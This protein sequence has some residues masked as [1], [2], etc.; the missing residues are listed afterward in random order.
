MGRVGAGLARGRSR[1]SAPGRHSGSGRP[2]SARTG[3][4]CTCPGPARASGSAADRRARPA[5]R[6]RLNPASRAAA[7]AN[8]SAA[9]KL[10]PAPVRSGSA[11]AGRGLR[12]H[13]HC[14]LARP[15]REGKRALIVQSRTSPG[16]AP[17]R[18]S[19]SLPVQRCRVRGESYRSPQRRRNDGGRRAQHC[20]G[21]RAV[22]PLTPSWDSARLVVIRS[23]SDHTTWGPH[24]CQESRREPRRRPP[25]ASARLCP[26]R[27]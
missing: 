15:G 7:S 23:L 19:R 18:P 22:T 26:L 11:A 5:R 1:G 16:A 17:R 21:A 25:A 8:H 27:L 9:G 3:R 4:G 10:S 12:C 14:G 13:L 24:H 2:S 6:P 20:T